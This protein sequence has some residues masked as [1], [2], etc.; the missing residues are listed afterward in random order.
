[1]NL[2]AGWHRTQSNL[3]RNL[4]SFFSLL[5]QWGLLLLLLMWMGADFSQDA[6]PPL[7]PPHAW[8]S[9]Q[10]GK[11][12]Q[13]KCENYTRPIINHV[14]SFKHFF[15][16]S[17]VVRQPHTRPLLPGDG[18]RARSTATDSRRKGRRLGRHLEEHPPHHPHPS[19]TITATAVTARLM[20]ARAH[21]QLH[22]HTHGA[23]P[24]PTHQIFS[25]PEVSSHLGGKK[26]FSSSF[27]RRG[28]STR[29]NLVTQH[30][31]R[32]WQWTRWLCGPCNLR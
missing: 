22:V 23:P 14:Y 26:N 7:P 17:I 9:S 20:H 2:R 12:L 25:N 3:L 32:V 24:I 30:S 4:Y 6:P 28:K 13:E 15:S 10:W 11:A 18:E 1:M 8:K 5:Y 21:A 31:A 19:D 27:E 29:R 16:F